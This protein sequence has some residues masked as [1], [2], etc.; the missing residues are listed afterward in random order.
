MFNWKA[1]V[2]FTVLLLLFVYGG[3]AGGI[4]A[5][6]IPS[7]EGFAPVLFFDSSEQWFPCAINFDGTWD[8]A[9]SHEHYNPDNV[10]K[11]LYTRTYV[12][13]NYVVFGYFM[14][15]AYNSFLNVHETDAETYF[16]WVRDNVP[17]FVAPFAHGHPEVRRVYSINEVYGYVQR[18]SHGIYLDRLSALPCDYKI[19]VSDWQFEDVMVA[20][21]HRSEFETPQGTFRMDEPGDV[22]IK[23]WWHYD[24]F[25]DPDVLLDNEQLAVLNAP[26][27]IPL[28]VVGAISPTAVIINGS[29][30]FLGAFAL[31]FLYRDRAWVALSLLS[32]A[33]VTGLMVGSYMRFDP[34][35]I[36]LSP[37]LVVLRALPY[38]FGVITAVSAGYF[39]RHVVEAMV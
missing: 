24:W 19:R 25:W 20:Y 18:G 27:R 17:V 8:T 26:K 31:G 14:F 15:Y 1:A 13:E 32:W 36:P 22:N 10:P 39:T 28:S 5:R 7:R 12:R 29:L 11:L 9:D 35:E 33:V 21:E 6:Y 2:V 16:V 23:P 34:T 30:F 38:A 4:L 3:W 37:A